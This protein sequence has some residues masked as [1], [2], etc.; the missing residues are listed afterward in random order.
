MKISKAEADRKGFHQFIHHD[1]LVWASRADRGQH[2]N[3]CLCYSCKAFHPGEENNCPHAEELFDLLTSSN[4][5]HTA[6][7]AECEDFEI[8]L[9]EGDLV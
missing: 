2:R 9:E 3:R 1:T 8:E 5:I 4:A 6:P 7:V